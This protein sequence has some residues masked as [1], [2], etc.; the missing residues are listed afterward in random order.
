MSQ[1]FFILREKSDP[2]GDYGDILMH[3]MSAHLGPIDGLIQLERT[4][5]FIPPISF[6]GIGDIIVTDELRQSLENSALKGFEFRDVIKARIVDLPWHDG[7]RETE[8]PPTYPNEGE[9]EGY[10]LDLPHSQ[11]AAESIG[12]V[13]ELVLRTVCRTSRES[14]IVSSPNEITL[15]VGDWDGSDFFRAEGVGYNYVTATAKDWLLNIVPE[16]VEFKD[17]VVEP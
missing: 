5:P 6:P 4:A 1:R 9:P 3:G 17:A 12:V 11:K 10:I 15:H 13:W 8:E 14:R 16:V 7:T 2:W